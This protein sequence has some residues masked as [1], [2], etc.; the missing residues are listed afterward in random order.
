[1]SAFGFDRGAKARKQE[2]SVKHKCT[3]DGGYW[4]ALSQA[5]ACI[6]TSHQLRGLQAQELLTDSILQ[7]EDSQRLGRF[8]SEGYRVL[9]FL[10]Y[11]TVICSYMCVVLRSG[12]PRRYF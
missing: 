4:Q 2:E 11:F 1:M 8:L 7:R 10:H 6:L 9:V 5:A 12:L 3:S